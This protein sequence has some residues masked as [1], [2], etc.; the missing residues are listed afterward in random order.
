MII[1]ATVMMIRFLRLDDVRKIALS[2][3]D[4][5]LITFK[6]NN[7]E[8]KSAFSLFIWFSEFTFHSSEF[9]K[10]RSGLKLINGTI[11]SSLSSSS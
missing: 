11:I 3:Y 8:N 9:L 7:E 10:L 6:R 2:S 1:M 5:F 4:S